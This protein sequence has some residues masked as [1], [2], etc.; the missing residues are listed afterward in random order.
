M[1][2][3][4]YLSLSQSPGQSSSQKYMLIIHISSAPAYE[5]S[6]AEMFL[7]PVFTAAVR[8]IHVHSEGWWGKFREAPEC[9]PLMCTDVPSFSESEQASNCLHP[10]FRSVCCAAL[11]LWTCSDRLHGCF[12]VCVCVREVAQSPTPC[13]YQ[14]SPALPFLNMSNPVPLAFW[15]VSVTSEQRCR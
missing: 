7:L 3:L 2:S 8:R 11:W 4:E 10:D 5:S 6:Q 14:Q 9:V 13:H 15:D 12:S 1:S